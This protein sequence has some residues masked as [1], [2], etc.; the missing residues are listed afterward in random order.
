MIGAAAH[1]AHPQAS[2]RHPES[3]HPRYAGRRVDWQH[4]NPTNARLRPANGARFIHDVTA[5]ALPPSLNSPYSAA[6]STS[7]LHFWAGAR[8]SYSYRRRRHPMGWTRMAEGSF[9]GAAGGREVTVVAARADR[10]MT[11]LNR[12]G[13]GPFSTDSP[14]TPP[15]P[16]VRPV[17]HGCIT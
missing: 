2:I 9:V 13:Q 17:M 5:P 10:E 8:Q 15:P 7:L 4:R 6:C 14:S 12:R 3:R 16:H 1:V 11:G